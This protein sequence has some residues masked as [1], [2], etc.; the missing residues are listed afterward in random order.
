[1]SYQTI[2]FYKFVKIKNPEELRVFLRGVCEALELNGRILIGEEGINAGVSG[3]EKNVEQF[4]KVLKKDRNFNDLTFREMPANI[5]SYHKLVVKVRNEIITLGKKVEMKNKAQYISP[6][7]LKK[8]Y[9]KNQDF[10]IIDA[11]NNYEAEVG[12]FKNAV[13]LPIESFK[14]LPDALKQV[15][16]LKDKKIVTYCTGGIRCEKATA[17]MKQQGFQNVFQLQGGII[18]YIQK[19]PGQEFEGSLFVF[20]DRLVSD[21]GSEKKLGKCEICKKPCND[22]TDCYNLECDKLFICCEDCKIK[23]KNTCSEK[24]MKFGRM[25]SGEFN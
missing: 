7:R 3:S 20:D 17:Y 22:Y 15:E 10:V 14:E 19:F 4:K 1:M 16:N 11:R 23:M 21:T 13:V 12:K 2:T 5:N 8:W 25:R 18:N 9:E 6:Q 24:C